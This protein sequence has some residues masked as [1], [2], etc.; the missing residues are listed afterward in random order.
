MLTNRRDQW[1]VKTASEWTLGSPRESVSSVELPVS[2]RLAKTGFDCLSNLTCSTDRP[3][4]A[5]T[6]AAK[7]S[8]MFAL[9]IAPGHRHV[10]RE[11]DSKATKLTSRTFTTNRRPMREGL[12][13]QHT[14]QLKG[15][16]V[17]PQKTTECLTD[18]SERMCADPAHCHR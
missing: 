8:C 7:R 18:L 4:S 13:A 11:R 14:K 2:A 12:L 5:S 10:L 15:Q 1:L 6:T 17:K 16:I 9:G 3:T